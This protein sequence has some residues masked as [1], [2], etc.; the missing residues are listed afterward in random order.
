MI[1]PKRCFLWSTRKSFLP[2]L[3]GVTYLRSTTTLLQSL[4]LLVGRGA[5]AKEREMKGARVI[6][7]LMVCIKVE[8]KVGGDGV[9]ANDVS[10]EEGL[11]GPARR[12]KIFCNIFM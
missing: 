8:V 11:S 9:G 5:Q 2:H 1:F 12:R 10:E 3:V 6:K 4:F 7:A